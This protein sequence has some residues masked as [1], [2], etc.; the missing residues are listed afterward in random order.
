MTAIP[1]N[2]DALLTRK[3]TAA[4]LTEVGFKTAPATLASKATRGGGPQYRIFGRIPL[5]RWADSLE[6]AH[7]KLSAPR[8]ST[9]EGDA[10][11]QAAAEVTVPVRRAC[12]TPPDRTPPRRRP[13]QRA[14]IASTA[15]TS[16]AGESLK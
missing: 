11:D 10:I 13:R 9:S 7:S 16:T 8:H 14:T 12:D 3:Q 6:W 1:T 15:S 2:T 5:Y 4:A